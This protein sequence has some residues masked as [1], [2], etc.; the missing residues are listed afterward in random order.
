MSA[1]NLKDPNTLSQVLL[2]LSQPDT[3]VIKQ[4]EKILKPFLNNAESVQPLM[5]QLRSSPDESVRHHSALLLKKKIA[6][7][8]FK[9]DQGQRNAI[10]G[11]LLNIL[12]QEPS[13][14]IC[15]AVAGLIGCLTAVVFKNKET[16]DEIFQLLM[17]LSRAPEE[18]LRFL[19]YNLLE[20]LA[21]HAT[22]FLKPHTETLAQMFVVGCQDS[23]SI[24][25]VSAFEA[26][27]QYINQL[28]NHDDIMI[29]EKVLAPMVLVM[30]NCLKNGQD[31]V[32]TVG[33]EVIEECCRLDKPLVN[34][35]IEPLLQFVLSIVQNTELDA[36]LRNSAG[37]TFMSMCECRPK[38]LAKKNLVAPALQVV[39]EMVA[40]QAPE[41][42]GAII[43]CN[44]NPNQN[45][46][47]EDEDDDDYV[48]EAEE[49]AQKLPQMIIDCM[50]LNI[51]S[52]YFSEPALALCSQGMGSTDPQMRKA[53]SAVLGTIAEGCA[54]RIREQLA[55]ILPVLL[56]A[57]QDEEYYVRECA[58]FA[59]GQFS[60]WCQPEIL[61]YNAQVLPVIFQALNDQRPNV[62]LTSCYV[63]ESFCE[64][65]QRETLYPYLQQLM[66]KLALLLQ[67][68]ASA[69]QEMALTAISSTAAAAEKDFLPYTPVTCNILSHLIFATEP[70]K[71]AIRGRAL[72]CLGHVAVA[73]GREHFAQY[74]DIGMRS[75]MQ[76]LQL[77][78]TES[79]LAEYSFLFFANSAKV[80]GTHM[81]QFLPTLVP[82]LLEAAEESEVVFN[83]PDDDEEENVDV[84]ADEDDDDED[85]DGNYRI[86]V[87]EGF[88]NT[89]MAAI[90]ALGE[91]A[92][93]T[94]G[95]FQPYVE[96]TYQ[97]LMQNDL[98]AVFS[99]HEAVKAEAL[100]VLQHML[101][102]TC[103]ANGIQT[104]PAQGQTVA[105]TQ[106]VQY[107]ATSI[108]EMY[109]V[110]LQKDYEKKCV[111]AA[112]EGIMGVLRMLGMSALH[113]MSVEGEK[114]LA[115]ML[116]EAILQLLKEKAPC[117][118]YDKYEDGEDEDEDD[119]DH[120]NQ[121]MD[122]VTDVI[123]QLAKVLG[124]HYVQYFNAFH[125]PLLRFTKPARAHSDRA[126][127]IG[128]Y[129]EVVAEIGPQAMEY[130]EVLLPMIQQGL[131]DSMES[132][133]RNSAFC[134]AQLLESTGTAMSQY[135]LHMLQ[136]LHPICVRDKSALGSE[137]GA[138][139]DNAISAVARMIKMAPEVVPLAQVLPVLLGALPMRGDVSE[140]PFVYQ[141]LA[142]L[143][144]KQEPTATG[145]CLLPIISAC[146]EVC[147]STT[148]MEETKK[149]AQDFLRQVAG[150][151][152]LM[153][154]ITDSTIQQQ[155][156]QLLC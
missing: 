123:G 31:E 142:T 42:T 58:C 91:L 122:G 64:N 55:G 34:N 83:G 70:A 93:V 105:M 40:K 136:W 104:E 128:C 43:A 63:L 155:M 147:G 152:L 113:L 48:D 97:A 130:V 148:A 25:A 103:A 85:N 102:V 125:G 5:M 38:L 86:K 72:E 44:P 76:A 21:E 39:M 150:T 20:Q 98:G 18:N 141:T 137:G 47:L 71:F 140:G 10:K 19:N 59:L 36:A 3:A 41:C 28:G 139:I 108:F 138:D 14:G 75:A 156:Q 146:I 110:T 49:D 2:M 69:T 73:I 32:L 117:Q 56:N 11:E 46:T 1:P 53:G 61:Q 116:M 90:T 17:T 124:V 9:F 62:Q 30:S 13:K 126:M 67:S 99:V 82:L 29:L 68:P 129:A 35:S 144:L 60:E 118:T 127:A 120:D 153:T 101:A 54:D 37:Q 132:V 134:L 79:T 89:K 115:P 66:D 26:T 133:R 74:F 57:V 77:K 111:A 87:E 27:A 6:K 121:V 92:S 33:L 4:A 88:I 95:D 52:K 96:R 145:D 131:Q 12:V 154:K 135:F 149:V 100:T 94:K 16:W 50:A 8:F 84:V 24:V 23:V 81:T 65:L 22:D 119:G 143:V 78:E 7:H 45:A 106:P 109:V 112:C 80:M 107:C 114:P 151:S 15:T 51:P